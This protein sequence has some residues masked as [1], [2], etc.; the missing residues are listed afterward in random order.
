MATAERLPDEGSRAAVEAG[1]R[2][3]TPPGTWAGELRATVALALPVIGTQISQV[4]INTTDVILLGRLS[5]QALAS[6]TL[7][8]NTFFVLMIFVLGVLTA[9]T[10]LTAQA[11]GAGDLRG[12]RRTVRQGLW[13]AAALSVPAMAVLWHAEAILLALDQSAADAAG[14]G[15]YVRA[16]LWGFPG[17]MAFVVLRAFTAALSRP[18]A[19]LAITL[20]GVA[21]NA[22]AAYALIF[23]AFGLPRL[24]LLGAGIASATVNT[25]MFAGLAGFVLVDRG[26]RRYAV[27]GRFWRADWPRF[28]AIFR[29]GVPI[30]VTLLLE[31]G[32]FAGS[33]VLMGWI[34]TEALAAHAIAI[35]LAAVAFM[36]PLG[37]GMAGAV[38]VGLAHGAGDG[39][40]VRRAGWSAVGLGLAASLLSA[41]IFLTVPGLL[42]GAFLDP[43]EPGADRVA[44][45][46]V[47]LLAV[48]AL[49]QL[50]DAG[51]AVGANVLRGVSDTQVP[52]IL[53]AIGYWLVGFPLAYLLAIRGGLGAPG[54]WY[55][56]ATGLFIV[57]VLLISRFARHAARAAPPSPG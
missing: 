46:A 38:R 19:A 21:L 2:P 5:P 37:I 47:E 35:Q 56:L 31:V 44:A 7:G 51:Q 12:M 39:A 50:A 20:A 34:G 3:G 42:V 57:A 48:A 23:G 53:A 13:A 8:A 49:F 22:A 17:A 43:A 26:M 27:F 9:V 6:G 33:S 18:G 16:L 55:G 1:P 4:A 41:A 40:G 30:G 29:I 10:P 36:V 52:M 14:A 54:V 25:A 11:R 24:E 28:R 32:M 15:E 45:L